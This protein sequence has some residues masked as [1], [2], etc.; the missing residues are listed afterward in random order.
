MNDSLTFDQLFSFDD[1]FD[2]KIDTHLNDPYGFDEAYSPQW[3]SE[4]HIP[5]LP[6]FGITVEK[7]TIQD[8]ESPTLSQINPIKRRKVKGGRFKRVS[9]LSTQD[10]SEQGE[11]V[12]EMGDNEFELVVPKL[13]E[14]THVE[15]KKESGDVSGC[16]QETTDTSLAYNV[17]TLD[18]LVIDI[19][20]ELEPNPKQRKPRRD[21]FKSRVV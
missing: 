10:G 9:P 19:L 8:T 1:Q 14:E 7:K 4:D 21:I 5:Q 12:P 3:M 17:Q 15:D 20:K 13:K 6:D 16:G 2:F 18:S 11:T